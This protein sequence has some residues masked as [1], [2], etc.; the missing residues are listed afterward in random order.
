MDTGAPADETGAQGAGTADAADDRPHFT[1]D[2]E[3]PV[4]YEEEDNADAPVGPLPGDGP[5]ERRARVELP[6]AQDS[7]GPTFYRIGVDHTFTPGCEEI[8]FQCTRIKKLEN[9]APAG[10]AL[11]RLILIANCI[12]KVEGLEELVNLEHLELYQNLVKRI[13]NISHLKSLRILDFSFN[14]IRSIAPL[15][16]CPF[17]NLDQLYLS[18]NKI[19]DVEAIF[20]FKKLR[21]LELGSNRIRTIPPQLSELVDLQELWLGKNKIASMVLP[22]LPKL[23][24]LSLQNNRLEVWDPQLFKNCPNL[25]FFYLGHNNLPDIPE[26]LA[27]LSNLREIDLAKNAIKTIRP[28][29]QLEKLRDL[30]MNDNQVEDLDEVRNLAAYP[31]LKTIYLERNPMHG[32]GDTEKEEKYK[33]A[34]L[35]AVPDL[36]QLDAVKLNLKVNVVTDGSERLVKS[37]LKR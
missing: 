35:E 7:S 18:S 4:V 22:P 28:M 16:N 21:L 25:E 30:W 33:Q 23:K 20:H 31:A 13:E 37:V 1:I 17:A 26:E 34:I 2:A 12:E 27:M 36:V 11:K 24:H 6:P 3:N 8:F 10:A 15:G 9:L 32:L 19:E 29:P 14:K 5:S